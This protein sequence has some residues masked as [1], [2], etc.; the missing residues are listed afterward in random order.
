MYERCCKNKQLSHLLN[1]FVL[2]YL[3]SFWYCHLFPVGKCDWNFKVNKTSH[4]EA[5][6]AEQE[7]SICLMS[8]SATAI[9]RGSLKTEE[10]WFRCVILCMCVFMSASYVTSFFAIVSVYFL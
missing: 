9:S 5:T 2:V 6:P 3:I 10:M 4:M 7:V 1:N 8:V